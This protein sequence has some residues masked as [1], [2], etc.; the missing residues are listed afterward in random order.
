MRQ[1]NSGVGSPVDKIFSRDERAFLDE[2]IRDL[3]GAS[4][5]SGTIAEADLRE[6]C[7]NS[8]RALHQGITL[9]GGEKADD[10][11]WKELRQ[12]LEE[13]SE[14]RVFDGSILTIA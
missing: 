1:I 7:A 4:R 3:R 10:P 6:E 12:L 13:I 5:A 14:K 9:P 8:F 11:R 2:W